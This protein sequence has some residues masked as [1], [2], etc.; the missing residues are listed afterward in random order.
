MLKLKV[1]ISE[2]APGI[3]VAKIHGS[4]DSSNVI[5]LKEKF[6]RLFNER[7]FKVVAD[8]KNTLY[9]SSVGIGC[10]ISA[11]TTAIKHGGR[12][13]FVATSKNVREVF[14]L[15]GLTQIMRFV[16]DEKTAI[17]QFTS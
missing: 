2:L 6:D 15:V 14:E 8:L 10:F 16:E 12:L 9:I 3:W 5:K 7:K 4:V 17:E 11:Y 1:L 13:V